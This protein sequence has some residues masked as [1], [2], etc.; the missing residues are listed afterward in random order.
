ML[1]V[2]RVNINSAQK[3]WVDVWGRDEGGRMSLPPLVQD[4]DVSR[5]KRCDGREVCRQDSLNSSMDL[6]NTKRCNLEMQIS[7]GLT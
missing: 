5:Q 4:R 3:H 2:Q 7:V 6:P 1:N